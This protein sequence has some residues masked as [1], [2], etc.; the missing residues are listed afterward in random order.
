MTRDLGL[1]EK[2]N[3]SSLSICRHVPHIFDSQSILLLFSKSMIHELKDKRPK[4]QISLQ[5]TLGK[6]Y[7]ERTINGLRISPTRVRS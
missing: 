7:L 5:H 1:F 6:I 3:K 2:Q 4:K